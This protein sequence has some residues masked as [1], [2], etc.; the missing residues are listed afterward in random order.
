LF[1]TGREAASFRIETEY[2]KENRQAL[3]DKKGKQKSEVW[4]SYF[5]SEYNIEPRGTTVRK[6]TSKKPTGKDP[7]SQ[8]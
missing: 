1:T 7:R 5:A 3:Q 8:A 4:V 2:E 6:A